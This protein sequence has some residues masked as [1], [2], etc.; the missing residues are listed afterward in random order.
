MEGKK[1]LGKG[2][3]KGSN[4]AEVIVFLLTHNDNQ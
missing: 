4:Y 2:E 1:E 3:T